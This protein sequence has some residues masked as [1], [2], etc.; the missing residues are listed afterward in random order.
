LLRARPSSCTYLSSDSRLGAEEP[1]GD[2]LGL[3]GQY[4]AD[5]V[6]QRVETIDL[7]S[8]PDVGVG[9]PGRVEVGDLDDVLCP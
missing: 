8:D 6:G 9:G 2:R 4:L 5:S 3:P 1:C 7:R